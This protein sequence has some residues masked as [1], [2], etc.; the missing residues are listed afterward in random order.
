MAAVSRHPVLADFLRCDERHAVVLPL[1]EAAAHGI[2]I[3]ISE[4]LKR[5][6][7]ESR[8]RASCAVSD[9]RLI[10]IRQHFVS[11]HFKEPAGQENGLV[12][13][14]LFPLIRFPN[15]EKREAIVRIHLIV[16]FLNR[17]FFILVLRLTEKLFKVAHRIIVS[18]ALLASHS[19]PLMALSRLS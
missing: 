14:T 15:V 7:G 19:Q 9:N 18:C 8:P 11:F 1:R 17:Y 16:Y 6:G 2:Y 10:F 12:Q 5:F 13:M 3:G 4:V